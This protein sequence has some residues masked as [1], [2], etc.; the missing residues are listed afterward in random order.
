MMNSGPTFNSA[1]ET[2]IRALTILEACYPKSLDTQRL[3]ELDYLVVHSGDANGPDSLHVALPLRSGEL[4]VRREIVSDGLL[5]MMSRGLVVREAIS[6]GIVYKAAEAA[7]PF[8]ASLT[9]EYI[10]SLRDRAT[11]AADRFVDLSHQ[12]LREITSELFDSWTTQFQA[13]EQAG[14]KGSG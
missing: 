14:E 5:L 10:Q 11:W 4:L 3:V 8:L 9:S 13:S 6:E 12:Q 1:L 2:G 7:A